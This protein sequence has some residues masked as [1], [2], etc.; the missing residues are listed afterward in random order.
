ML[1]TELRHFS[2]H[3]RC[4]YIVTTSPGSNPHRRGRP[5]LQ[6]TPDPLE[7]CSG[8]FPPGPAAGNTS[9]SS[10][11]DAQQP[12][13]FQPLPM[14]VSSPFSWNNPPSFPWW[15]QLHPSGCVAGTM[16][17]GKAQVT[18]TCGGGDTRPRCPPSPCALALSSWAPP[19]PLGASPLATLMARPAQ[20]RPG[21]QRRECPVSPSTCSHRDGRGTEQTFQNPGPN[22]ENEWRGPMLFR[23]PCARMFAHISACGYVC[24]QGHAGCVGTSVY[25]SGALA[26]VWAHAHACAGGWMTGYRGNSL[27]SG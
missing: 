14:L 1:H 8:L 3:D 2:C 5:E 22:P 4:Y 27:S 23:C 18:L 13:P 9:Y 17:D 7:G 12:C 11:P 6:E 16:G 10:L 21:L 25:A 26:C 24:R 15:V 20:H 19:L